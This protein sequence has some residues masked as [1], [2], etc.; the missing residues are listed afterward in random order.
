[1]GALPLNFTTYISSLSGEG[2]LA[3]G[4]WRGEFGEGNL[5]RGIWRGEFGEG[6][7]ARGIWVAWHSAS[8]VHI[9]EEI[10]IIYMFTEVR[11]L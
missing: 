10:N 5:A 6:N 8:I 7:L 2:N 9:K 4:I 3:R 11:T 1:M